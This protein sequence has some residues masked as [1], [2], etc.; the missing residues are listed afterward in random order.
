MTIT[1]TQPQTQ[2]PVTTGTGTA[3]D[4]V[5]FSTNVDV[6]ALKTPTGKAITDFEV[7]QSLIASDTQLIDLIMRSESMKDS[8][9]QYWFNLTEV[10]NGD[11]VEKL[12]GILVRER[13]K[14]AE[15]ESKYGKQPAKPQLSAEEIRKRNE[16][17]AQKRAAEQAALAAKEKAQESKVEETILSEL[18]NAWN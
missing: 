8:E 2:T 5:L 17:M 13:T 3:L 12:R 4:P 10:M 15:I 18:D 16:E 9:R 1:T 14:L 6:N 7:P 11:Q